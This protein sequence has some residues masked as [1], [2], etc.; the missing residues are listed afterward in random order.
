MPN[1][2]RKIRL[3]VI[4]AAAAVLAGVGVAGAQSITFS[5][6]PVGLNAA[7]Q[8]V[9]DIYALNGTT[10]GN[11]MAVDT[12]FKTTTPSTNLGINVT[13]SGSNNIADILGTQSST[14]YGGGTYVSFG[15]SS[16]FL[17]GVVA[18]GTNYD[19]QAQAWVSAGTLPTNFTAC[20]SLEVEGF[21]I[22]G[23]TADSTVNGGKGLMIG[24]LVIPNNTAATVTVQAA[25]TSGVLSTGTLTIGP[26]SIQLGDTNLDG[27]VN[28][29]DLTNLLRNLGGNTTSLSEATAWADGNFLY[30]PATGANATV[31]I[32]DLTDLLRNLGYSGAVPSFTSLEADAAVAVPEPASI[33]LLGLGVVGLLARRRRA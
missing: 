6:A 16:S 32:S 24:Q 28:I 2:S 9:F 30:N 19:P 3:P 20:S 27:K 18:N 11:V 33:G 14:T 7:G 8:D 25:P 21:Q 12:T 10:G 5:E 17:A 15:G 4:A 1:T 31:N 26:D 29:T 22:G 23:V 13:T